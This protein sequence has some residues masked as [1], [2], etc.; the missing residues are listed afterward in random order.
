MDLFALVDQIASG[1]GTSEGTERL[2]H[3]GPDA[4]RAVAQYLAARDLPFAAAERVEQVVK[5]VMYGLLRGS[6]SLDT[7]R[8]VARAQRE[9][10]LLLKYK[11]YAIKAT[12]PLGYSIFF[13][14]PGEGFSFQRHL[15]HKVELF[16]VLDAAPGA[17]A[18][19]CEYDDWCSV[20]DDRSLSSWLAGEDNP[21]LDAFSYRVRPGD[22]LVIDRLNVVHTVV[23][24][25]VEEF[26][27]TSVDMVDRLFDQNEGKTIPS[28]FRREKT[29]P[30]LQRLPEVEPEQH[31]EIL[32]DEVVTRPV[33]AQEH[34]WG[35]VRETKTGPMVARH[36]VVRAGA[37]TDIF[38]D[39]ERAASLFVRAGKGALGLGT[40]L[41]LRRGSVPL[42]QVAAGDLLTISAG[43]HFQLTA[44]P[45]S[46]L[47]VSEQRI[48]LTVAFQAGPY[49]A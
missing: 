20:F 33:Q 43:A 44:E 41:D 46:T 9:I 38:S 29:L 11:S 4:L 40:A 37:S 24:C 7:I 32:A 13:Q 10:G 26:A 14:E 23:G 17:F 18:F 39:E 25:V 45:G 12:S 6:A 21:R 47:R 28:D 5:R 34:G 49:E 15:T 48:P 19:I 16:H 1:S 27:T 30:R 3:S 8:E 42:I 31:V 36:V 35:Q 22:M 2:I